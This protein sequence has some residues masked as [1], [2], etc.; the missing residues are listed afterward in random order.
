MQDQSKINLMTQTDLMEYTLGEIYRNL[1]NYREM[2]KVN[3]LYRDDAAEIAIKD[4]IFMNENNEHILD[5]KLKEVLYIFIFRKRQLE[6]YSRKFY[7]RN[8]FK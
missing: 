3:K 1:N 4:Y 2:V 8:T 7:S 5:E 6:N